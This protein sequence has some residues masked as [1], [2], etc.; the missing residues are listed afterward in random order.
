MNT[1]NFQG[2]TAILFDYGG[3]LDS[4]G[5]HW[6]VR[7]YALYD[8]AG[9][10]LPQS[11]I[12]R[13]F[14]HAVNTC[15]ADS[16]VLSFGLKSLV[17]YHVQLQFEALGI[18]DPAK[19][20][21]LANRFRSDCESTFKGRLGFLGRIKD[22]YRLGIVSNFYGNL[23]TVLDEAGLSGLFDV[24]IDSNR[25]GIRKPDPR[26]FELALSRMGIPGTEAVFVGDSFDRDMVPAMKMGMKAV[27]LKGEDKGTD[28]G[29]SPD[30]V[31]AAIGRL[32]DLE[33]LLQ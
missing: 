22:S 25:V 2:C 4:D 11:E 5:I 8:E 19:E 6:L 18:D 3:T 33:G 13:A 28:A 1:T 32:A 31:H 16:R 30:A 14:Y 10:A 9:M 15:Y 17:D 27:W 24:V 7:F 20:K 12:T 26:I 23:A 21:W 29:A